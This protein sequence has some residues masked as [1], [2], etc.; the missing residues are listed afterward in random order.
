MPASPDHPAFD[1][2]PLYQWHQWLIE[3]RSNFGVAPRNFDTHVERMLLVNPPWITK[4]RFGDALAKL[5]QNTTLR[6]LFR[7]GRIVWG[8]VI[9]ANDELFTPAPSMDSY[10]YDRA[11]EIVFSLEDRVIVTP[12]HL[13]HVA[14]ELSGLKDVDDLDGE[15]QSWA[16]YL[17]AETTRVAGWQVP[18]RLSPC[19]L[20]FVSTTLFRR[21]HLPDG[22]LCQPLLPIVVVT[23]QPHFAMPLPQLYWPESLLEWWR[24]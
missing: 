24:R 13:E 10:T 8:H 7:T 17:N 21:S 18:T 1:G 16:D 23:E 9:Q 12:G 20:C 15:L 22:I 5:V 2:I 14:S 19:T 11:G 4:L 6:R 3:C